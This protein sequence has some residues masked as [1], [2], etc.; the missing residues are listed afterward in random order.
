MIWTRRRFAIAAPSSAGAAG[1]RSAPGAVP[2]PTPAV[3]W[4]ADAGSHPASRI[5]WWYLT[6]ALDTAT[7]TP[8]F[9]FQ[10]TFFRVAT[11]LAG[12]EASRFQASQLVFA[13]AAVTDLAARRLRHDQRIARAGFGIADAAVGNTELVLRDWTLVRDAKAS[14]AAGAS[15][16]AT[17]AAS[18]TAGFRIA[19]VLTAS[20]PPLLQ[21]RDGLSQKG[22]RPEQSSHY[23]SEPQ[24]VARGSLGLDGAA[25]SPVSGRAWL[26]HEWSD[27]LLDPQAVGWDW[28][29]MNLD[30]G[31]AL[32]AFRLRRAD[33]STLWAGGSFRARGSDAR[34][35]ASGEV[36]FA[37]GRRWTSPASKASYPVEWTVATPAGRF[38][39]QALLDDQELD[40]L[41]SS[42][43]VYWEGLSQLLDAGGRRVG[44]GY[45]EMTGY[46]GR[47]VL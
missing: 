39:A 18:T 31:S 34:N 4:P 35:F 47:L 5:E 45:L 8:A 22:P 10:V 29:G 24:L 46:A 21:G 27:S 13:H 26:D 42:G 16:Y 12:A 20:E 23:Y 43:A 17:V 6:G 41:A 9:G 7:R 2:V 44:L 30:D 11:G 3:H 37:P 38:A 1:T 19:L 25:P 32:T 28:I 14:A 15:R 40:A 33:G 36:S